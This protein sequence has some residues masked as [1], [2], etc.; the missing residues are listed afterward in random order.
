MHSTGDESRSSATALSQN[1]AS[2]VGPR[3]LV[4]GQWPFFAAPDLRFTAPTPTGHPTWPP[5]RPAEPGFFSLPPSKA[6]PPLTP[7]AS[8]G[9]RAHA[10]RRNMGESSGKKRKRDGE[11]S[12]GKPQKKVV[13]DAPPPTAIVASVLRPKLCPP[14]IG[15][16]ALARILVV[17]A[18]WLTLA[19]AT[20]PGI[21]LPQS[22]PFRAY[23]ASASRAQAPELLLH[24]TAHRTLDYT[25]TEEPAP[26]SAPLLNHYVGIYDPRTGRLEVMEA[27][28]MVVRGLVRA[29]QGP[30]TPGQESTAKQ[31]SVRV[32]A[33]RGRR[34]HA[35]A[36]TVSSPQGAADRRTDLGQTFGTKKAKKAI[37]DTVLN[38]I[39]PLGKAGDATAAAAA[40][41]A[42]GMDEA[43][44]ATLS[45]VGAVTSLMATRE[46]LQAVV[47]ETK[48]VPRAN[49][50]ATS[51]HDV[52]TAESMIGADVVGLVP[53]REWQEK[54]RLNEGV[55]VPSRFVASR[56]KRLAADE[57]ATERLRVLRYLE[58][59]LRFFVLSREGRQRGTR[60]VPVPDKLREQMGGDGV[61]E[62][63]VES[64][65]RKFSEAGAMRKF[66]VDL[67]MAHCCALALL[68]DDLEVATHELR[69]DLKLGDDR[70]M[71]QY[72]YEV[73]A[74]VR[75]VSAKDQ[76]GRSWCVARLEL[77]L[78]FPKQRQA[79]A[80]RR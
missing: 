32:V 42:A 66:H 80:R 38:V 62:A 58:L 71:N 79:G 52:Y 34:R 46:E 13:L 68:I 9:G 4:A 35:R 37:R 76:P 11:A 51:A 2:A 23:Q 59:V 25:G 53:V 15:R 78:K 29:R 39:A 41:A 50:E 54:M 47:D 74:R 57:G 12:V 69:Q 55:Q 44:R 48:P 21:E 45:N 36:D 65:R 1:L 26:G 77:P 70:A 49:L 63:V 18:R 8:T 33:C 22:L 56:I 30:A 31:V 16:P 17:G 40:A 6:A 60:R 73:G 67:L 7:C 5:G 10:R 3:V 43:S 61:P 72:F 20:A 19:T 24:S 27:K 75:R 28:K 64:I 14:V